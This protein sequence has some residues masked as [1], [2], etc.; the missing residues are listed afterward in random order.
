MKCEIELEKNNSAYKRRW[1]TLLAVSLASGLVWLSATDVV[2]VL[3]K[4]AAPKN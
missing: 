1:W 4:M 3:P 2:I